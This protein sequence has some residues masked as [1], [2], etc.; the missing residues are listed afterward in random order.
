MNFTHRMSIK[1][2]LVLVVG[3]GAGGVMAE[4]HLAAFASAGHFNE[5]G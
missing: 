5:G 1:I 4:R 3:L 2:V